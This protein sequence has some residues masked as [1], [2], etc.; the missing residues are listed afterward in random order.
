MLA[1]LGPDN[2]IAT[3]KADAKLLNAYNQYPFTDT[4]SSIKTLFSSEVIGPSERH[5]LSKRNVEYVVSDR[6]AVSWDHMIGYYF[7]NQLYSSSSELKVVEPRVHEKFDR[8]QNVNR[9]LDT[10]DIIVYDVRRYLA[11]SSDQGTKAPP[12]TPTYRPVAVVPSGRTPD[13]T[14]RTRAGTRSQLSGCN[15]QPENTSLNLYM[16]LLLM[17]NKTRQTGCVNGRMP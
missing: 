16:R 7:Y 3:S 14:D 10:G 9:L 6:K 12:K 2:R 4:G 15:A 11:S 13:V 8:L 5:T 1:T 17:L